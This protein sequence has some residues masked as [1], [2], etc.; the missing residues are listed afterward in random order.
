MKTLSNLKEG[1][2]D[3][4][5]I[6]QVTICAATPTTTWKWTLPPNDGVA[7]QLLTT[8]GN[9]G[10]TWGGS[11]TPGTVTSVGLSAPS[12][13][14]T[15]SGSPVTTSGTIALSLVDSTGTGGIVLKNTP[16]LTGVVSM[17]SRYEVSTNNTECAR[18]FRTTDGDVFYAGTSLG[19]NRAAKF[20]FFGTT[21]SITNYMQLGY[22]GGIA[23]TRFYANADVE[24]DRQGG[25]GGKLLLKSASQTTSITTAASG[26]DWTLTLPQNNGNAGQVLSTDGG[27][28]TSWVDQTGGGAGSGT[29]TSV[30]YAVDTNYLTLSGTTSPITVNGTFTIGLNSPQG[31]GG[32]IVLSSGPNLTDALLSGTTNFNYMQCS[33]TSG[34]N[35]LDTQLR[36]TNFN[37]SNIRYDTVAG[38]LEVR[39][40]NNPGA[41]EHNG[42]ES[43]TWDEFG[44]NVPKKSTLSGTDRTAAPLVVNNTASAPGNEIEALHIESFNMGLDSY[45]KIRFGQS[46]GGA[47]D[48]GE[49]TFYYNGVD[50]GINNV[51]L[52]VGGGGS[53][54]GYFTLYNDGRASEINTPLSF[55]GGAGFD[56]EEGTWTP[57]LK[58]FDQGD[59]AIVNPSATLS[60]VTAN[61]SYIRQGRMVTVFFDF[62][63]NMTN[64]D[65]LATVGKR[66]VFIA[67]V[68]FTCNTTVGASKFASRGWCT[69]SSFPNG[70]APTGFKAPLASTYPGPYQPTIWGVGETVS[71]G[72]QS[73]IAPSLTDWTSDGNHILI[74][75]DN[76][77]DTATLVLPGPQFSS[78][79]CISNFN[80]LATE[81][82]YD[83]NRFKGTLTYFIN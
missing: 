28:V 66:W 50:N 58:Y 57:A 56:Y 72:I 27:G 77:F 21:D 19:G 2:F 43:A 42:T 24:L 31:S 33:G 68:P 53:T 73:A 14:F 32:T 34:I 61:G 39:A 22:F 65:A 15:V 30:G 41:L 8:D 40:F 16:S 9:G 54:R 29:V 10:T 69:E 23:G 75:S 26:S 25:V 6:G 52:G 82:N 60:S 62:L 55:S 1:K 80:I 7:G 46:L 11:G 70:I 18:M 79:Q 47:G 74:F 35:M 38:R 81:P 17:D 64:G 51:T 49:L 4:L 36:L 83:G 78:N 44:F 37:S 45:Q 5:E 20:A 76:V 63:F 59:D 48:R 67:G 13:Q 3:S 12:G 71:L